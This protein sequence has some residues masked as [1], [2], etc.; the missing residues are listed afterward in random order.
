[1]AE[2]ANPAWRL[3]ERYLDRIE[4]R[5]LASCEPDSKPIDD[6]ISSADVPVLF[7]AYTAALAEIERQ[8]ALIE[9]FK[10]MERERWA[11]AVKAFGEGVRPSSVLDGEGTHG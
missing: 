6:A 3:D 4:A 7:A 5:F 9:T 2:T 8:A 1:M 11:S 10:R